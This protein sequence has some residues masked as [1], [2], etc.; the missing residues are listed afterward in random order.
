MNSTP[1]LIQPDIVTL[2][3]YR[4][5]S[6]LCIGG[7]IALMSGTCFLVQ[8]TRHNQSVRPQLH[9]PSPVTDEAA[10]LMAGCEKG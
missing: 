2:S 8:R 6:S 3:P 10:N 1:I 9:R 7:A 5:F 4:K